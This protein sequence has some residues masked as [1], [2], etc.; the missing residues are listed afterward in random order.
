[1]I[2]AISIMADMLGKIA[3]LPNLKSEGIKA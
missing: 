3:R 2:C 1:M